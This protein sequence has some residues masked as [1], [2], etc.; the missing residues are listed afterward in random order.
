MKNYPKFNT[1]ELKEI[2]GLVEYI[3]NERRKDVTDFDN[4]KNVFISGRKVA[5]IPTAAIDVVNTDSIG[6]FNFTPSY[7]YV[8]VDNAG[9]AEWRRAALSTW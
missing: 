7:L 4:L 8:L 5:K 3:V 1:N 2:F 9:T 6:D